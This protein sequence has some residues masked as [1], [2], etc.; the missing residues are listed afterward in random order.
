MVPHCA[1]GVV[2]S[3]IE[4]PEIIGDLPPNA[5]SDM[6]SELL[7]NALK[8]PKGVTAGYFHNCTT[9]SQVD[10]EQ[11]LR[12]FRKHYDNYENGLPGADLGGFLPIENEIILNLMIATN[13]ILDNDNKQLL[14]ENSSVGKTSTDNMY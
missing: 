13:N 8:E 12:I 4:E 7:I 10:C 9:L 1:G 11:V 3:L 14:S 6:H 5:K 2:A